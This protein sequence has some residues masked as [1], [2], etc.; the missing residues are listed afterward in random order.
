MTGSKIY[1]VSPRSS[2]QS[3]IKQYATSKAKQ[4]AIDVDESVPLKREISCSASRHKLPL[5][6]LRHHLQLTAE[7][8]DANNEGVEGEAQKQFDA[9]K[10]QHSW[11]TN[12]MESCDE[13]LLTLSNLSCRCY[14]NIVKLSKKL[15]ELDK[16]NTGSNN[17]GDSPGGKSGRSYTGYSS[18]SH[19][20]NDVYR[21][22]AKDQGTHSPSDVLRTSATSLTRAKAAAS[23]A[24]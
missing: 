16:K 4:Y 19:Q 11:D 20:L 5:Q 10:E 21:N 13:L 24:A 9:F 12:Q 1:C 15:A 23:T 8:R 2:L 3:L 18:Q 14:E 6:K 7:N 17:F 22:V